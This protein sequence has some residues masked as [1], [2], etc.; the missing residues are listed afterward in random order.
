M[1]ATLNRKVATN[2]KQPKKESCMTVRVLTVR[3]QTVALIHTTGQGPG[4]KTR[5][6][7]LANGFWQDLQHLGTLIHTSEQGL[8][9]K[10]N[11]NGAMPIL[12]KKD[13]P[14]FVMY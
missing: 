9:P 3:Q 13:R 1:A 14:P 8:G 5:K 2:P 4:P 11:I 7:Q 12:A 10:T 6:N